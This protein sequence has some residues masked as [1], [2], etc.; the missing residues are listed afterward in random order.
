VELEYKEKKGRAKLEI[1]MKWNL[2]GPSLEHAKKDEQSLK[3][4]KQF[5]KRSFN[6]L[7]ESLNQ[8]RLPSDQ[9]IEGFVNL[10][11]AFNRLA[12]KSAYEKDM[13]GFMAL[14]ARLESNAKIG[15]IEETKTLI[16]EIRA[17]KK[18]CHKSYRWK[19]KTA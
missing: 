13:P 10:S 18:S 15:R 6:S 2:E 1:E 14:V 17:A 4:I 7:R 9:E 5:I 19:E 8:N 11:K 3:E 16:E 12:K